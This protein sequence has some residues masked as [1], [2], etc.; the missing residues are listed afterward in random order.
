MERLDKC[1]EDVLQSSNYNDQS[2]FLPFM[3]DIVERSLKN[4]EMN[5]LEEIHNCEINMVAENSDVLGYNIDSKLI[6]WS[7][8]RAQATRIKEFLDSGGDI[9]II[10]ERLGRPAERIQEAIDEELLKDQLLDD[11]LSKLPEGVKFDSIRNAK[12][13]SDRL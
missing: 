7:E 4:T 10:S 13:M 1:R 2:D 9:G 8:R 11:T 3:G 5:N 6:I 12:E